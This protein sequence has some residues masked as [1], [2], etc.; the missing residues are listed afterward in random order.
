MPWLSTSVAS[1]LSGE[2]IGFA[3]TT[4]RKS[5][6]NS[7]LIVGAVTILL[8]RVRVRLSPMLRSILFVLHWTY[9]LIIARPVLRV[10]ILNLTHVNH[11]WKLTNTLVIQSLFHFK[12]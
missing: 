9:T 3:T 7:L 12:S 10:F 11:E 4:T 6:G 2:S 8:R 5:H 1:D